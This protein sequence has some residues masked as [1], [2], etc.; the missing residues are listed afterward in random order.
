MN[1]SAPNLPPIPNNPQP[2]T[3]LRFAFCGRV[4]T[5]DQQDPVASRNWQIARA[6][7][8]IEP[9]GGVIVAEFFDIGHSRSIPWR[10]RPEAARLL[11]ALRDPARGFDAVVIGEPQRTFYGN[12]F[13]LTFPLFVHYGVQLWVPEVGGAVDPASDA[14]DVVMALYGG[15]SKGERNR[16][17]IRVK[18]AMAAQAATEGRFLGGRP[19][20]GYRLVDAGPHPNP[21]K[22]AD[23]RRL[24]R[25]DP[26]PLTAPVVKRIFAGY[27]SGKGLY[28]IA[29]ALTA[30]DIPSPSAYDRARNRHRTGQAWSKSAVR[31]I[32]L[33]PRY[34]GHQVWNRQ[35]KDEILLDVEDVALGHAT[36]LR[37][38]TPHDWIW[39]TQPVHQALVSPEDFARV[40]D[41][42]AAAGRRPVTRKPHRSRHDYVFK[43]LVWCAACDRRMQ[44][45]WANAQA[46]YRC[47]YPAEYALANKIDHPANVYLREAV[48]LDPIDTWLA[49]VFA[50]PRLADTL[51]RLAE[52]SSHDPALDLEVE[53][54]RRS[55]TE[56]DQRLARYRAA[57]EAGTDPALIARWTAEVNAQRVMA[58]TRLRQAAGRTAMAP[59]EI[60]A[61]VNAIG[62][63]VAVLHRADTADKAAIY[64]H[65]GLK[66]TYKQEAHI[67]QV[68]AQPDLTDMGFSS[69][70]RG[71]SAP[72]TQRTRKERVCMHSKVVLPQGIRQRDASAPI[73]PRSRRISASASRSAAAQRLPAQDRAARGLQRRQVPA[74]LRFRRVPVPLLVDDIGLAQA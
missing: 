23:G 22:A 50:P 16:I 42:M 1:P 20:Y 67:V 65:L 38:N 72:H 8:L 44:G 4:S 24:H 48:I 70:P 59:G 19:P 15:M 49:Q 32:L 51:H 21:G 73:R 62:D 2:A 9:V 6:R 43:G 5:E 7:A 61:L 47:R 34:T 53:A 36:K 11:A 30:E 39:S 29:E 74:V 17:K 57:L 26:D 33:N 13:G 12:Q 54:A 41:L 55:L 18:A 35:R 69:C 58:Q 31:A 3:P 28:A 63:L 64:R 68:H 46:Y 52:V 14:H 56:C 25:L 10:R 66:L 60:A 71:D 27:L 40:Q 45:H 37:W